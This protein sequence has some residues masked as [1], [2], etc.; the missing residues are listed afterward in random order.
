MIDRKFVFTAVNPCNGKHYTQDN[1]MV[2]CAKDAAVVPALEAY[3]VACERLGANGAHLTS[4]NKLIHRVKI[5]QEE[6]ESRIPDTVGAEIDRCIHGK[7]EI[8]QKRIQPPPKDE[9]EPIGYIAFGG[10][11]SGDRFPLTQYT[12]KTEREV[13]DKIM[14]GAK[15]EGW[16]GTVAERLEYLG[17]V[18]LPVYMIED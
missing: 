6:V 2:L 9:R 13:G 1:A 10:N 17:W 3:A 8:E 16:R 12:G 15:A 14:I 7:M 5:Y 18:I 4:I 11:A